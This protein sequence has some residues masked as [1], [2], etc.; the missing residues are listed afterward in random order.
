MKQANATV[1]RIRDP[2]LQ[3]A[4][5][6]LRRDL[7]G[8]AEIGLRLPRTQERI[9]EAL[10][11][12]PLEISTGTNLDSITAVV[13]G[14][15]GDGPAVLLRADM[16]ALPLV[17]RTGLDFAATGDA[18]HACGHDMHSTM[19][20]GAA[21]LLSD[22]RATLRGAVTLMFQ[23]GEEGYNG[24]GHMIEEGVLDAAGAPLFAAYALHVTAT[25]PSGLV[26][27]R[28]GP[29]LAAADRLRVTVRGRGGHGAS[30]H[31]AADPVQ[32]ACSMI[33]ALQV[34][35]T[36]EFSVLDPVIISVCRISGGTTHNVIP[37]TVEFEGTVRYFSTKSQDQLRAA[38]PRVC[39][40]VATA[41]RV[42]AETT[43]E[44]GFPPTV[45]DTV[46]AESAL[47]LAVDLFGEDRTELMPTPRP[48]SEDF[49]RILEAV[50]GAMLFIGA[51]APGRE[52]E[53]A[54]SNHSPE[55]VFDEAVLSDGA[56]FY[57]EL[58]LQHVR[59]S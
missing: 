42:E 8:R 18:M 57:A 36:R 40:S 53:T 25:R 28:P 39:R 47:A 1:G 19:L 11:G 5:V 30:P 24:A 15:G 6:P 50:P 21:H 29:F 46:A 4:L 52:L 12:L 22:Q 31:M 37:D 9:L 54:P 34:F 14:E 59:A 55:A 38:L 2:D 33:N 17:E 3:D 49:S 27:T 44:E 51:L 58:A 56:H 32:A 16:D 7:H 20:V 35:V 48:G 45:N 10:D 23:P 41:H 43:L 13:R 26:E